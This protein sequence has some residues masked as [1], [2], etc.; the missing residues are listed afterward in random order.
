MAE[1]MNAAGVVVTLVGRVVEVEKRGEA[2]KP[3]WITVLKTPNRDEFSG[4]DTWKVLS[5]RPIAKTGAD[6]EVTCDLRS[7]RRRVR[8][9]GGTNRDFFDVSVWARAQ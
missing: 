1:V 5:K 3:L 7:F 4:G 8:G 6:L 9:E 2:D